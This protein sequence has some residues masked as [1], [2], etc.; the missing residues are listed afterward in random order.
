MWDWVWVLCVVVDRWMCGCCE[1]GIE[2]GYCVWLRLCGCVAVV[3]VELGLVFVC[4]CGWC[5]CYESACM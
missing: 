5:D 2:F 3:N 4:G 1:C